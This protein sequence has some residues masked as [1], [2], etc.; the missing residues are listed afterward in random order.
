MNVRAGIPLK[1]DPDEMQKRTADSIVRAVLASALATFEHDRDPAAVIRREWGSDRDALAI[2]QRAASSPATTTTSA[3][4]GVFATARLVD[5]LKTLGPQSAGADLLSRG[6]VL[7]FEGINTITVP[8]FSVASATFS[9]FVGE[10]ASIPT[11]Q[12]ASSAGVSLTPHKMATIF[13]LTS[14][15]LMSSNAEALVK[16]VMMNSLAIALDGA[17]F[18]NAAGTAS[19]PAGLLNGVTPITAATGG[20]TAALVK[21]ISALVAAV[22]ATCGLNIVFVSDPGTATRLKMQAY[23]FDFDVLASNAVAANTLICVGLPGLVSAGSPTPRIDASR[24]AVTEMNTT[25]AADLAAGAPVRSSFQTDTP[26]I[27]FVS[28]MTWGLR[29]PSCLAYTTAVTW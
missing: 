5:W 25:P 6:T 23:D 29:S 15:Q 26:A 8:G 3:W 20:G 27:R 14:E 16:M 12:M 24:D 28:E 9:S 17:L 4:A 10:G 1:P 2:V 22:S 21:D 13:S 7:S 11:R 18:S 19:S